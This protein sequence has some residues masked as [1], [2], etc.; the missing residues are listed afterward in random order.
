MLA[1]AR[2]EFNQMPFIHS[3]IPQ[4]WTESSYVSGTG[5]T[6]VSKTDNPP[7]KEP[8]FVINK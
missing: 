4:K 5:D 8:M 3:F 1:R 7:L 2:W 6:A